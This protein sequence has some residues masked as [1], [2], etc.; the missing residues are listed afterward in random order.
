MRYRLRTL[1]MQIAFGR[2]LKGWEVCARAFHVK[3]ESPVGDCAYCRKNR[4][5]A[6]VIGPLGLGGV[7]IC[8][9]CA[10]TC[11]TLVKWW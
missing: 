5:L 9:E 4:K 3:D 8:R 2:E 6:E 1:M 7:F 11:V 10:A